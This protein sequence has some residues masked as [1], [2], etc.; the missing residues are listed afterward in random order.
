[1]TSGKNEIA[2]KLKSHATDTGSPS[3]QIGIITE[4]IN[5]LNEHFKKF[6]K[7][8]G[9]RRGFLKLI[10]QRRKLIEYLKKHDFKKYK[11]VIERLDLR[12]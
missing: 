1:M 4:R 10:S 12:K 6:P 3:V 2:E 5:K 7:D 9:S 11:E 8:L